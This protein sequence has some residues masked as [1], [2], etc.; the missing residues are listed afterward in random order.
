M[1]SAIEETAGA[2]AA[3]LPVRSLGIDIGGGVLTAAAEALGLVSTR[4]AL[5]ALGV[6][7]LIITV[8]GLGVN[9]PV[10]LGSG[11]GVGEAMGRGVSAGCA[12]AIAATISSAD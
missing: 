12:F 8:P 11:V 9:V 6:S 10:V 4:A 5:L 3:A 1:G 7:N 2:A